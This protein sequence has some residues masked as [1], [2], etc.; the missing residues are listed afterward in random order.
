MYI[1][2]QGICIHTHICICMCMYIYIHIYIC[3][4]EQICICVSVCLCIY[5]YM[6]TNLCM[7]I[8]EL[9]CRSRCRDTSASDFLSRRNRG[10]R[11][12][13]PQWMFALCVWDSQL[14]CVGC[15]GDTFTS[16]SLFLCFL[17]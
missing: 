16:Y 9:I 5:T 2:Y 17:Q 3:V 15:C 11:Y 6:Y 4:R 8:C 1:I 12:V 13:I 10:A 14:F 7:N